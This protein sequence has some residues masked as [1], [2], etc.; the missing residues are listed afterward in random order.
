MRRW[1]AGTIG[2]S[3]ALVVT[4]CTG[5]SPA[6]TPSPTPSPTQPTTGTSAGLDADTDTTAPTPGGGGTAVVPTTVATVPATAEEPGYVIAAPD[7][8]PVDGARPTWLDDGPTRPA[9]TATVH[10]DCDTGDDDAPGTEAAPLRTLAAVGVP[11]AGTDVV[12]VGT[13]VGQ[14]LRVTW[15]G[16]AADPVV[17]DG[18]DALLRS[19]GA[20]IGRGAII[21][22]EGDHVQVWGVR[23]EGVP[24]ETQ[25]IG[26]ACPG[27]DGTYQTGYVLG[28]RLR[29]SDSV[30]ARADI[31]GTYAGVFVTDGADRALITRSV[32]HDNDILTTGRDG[33]DGDADDAGAFGVVLHG[34]WAEVSWN[35]FHDNR[36]CSPDYFVDGSAVEIFNGSANTVHHNLSVDDHVFTELGRTG[37]GPETDTPMIGNVFHANRYITRHGGHDEGTPSGERFLVT[38]G[39]GRLGPVIATVATDNRVTILGSAGDAF[40]CIDCTADTLALGGNHLAVTRHRIWYGADAGGTYA[41]VAPD[42]GTS[43]GAVDDDDVVEPAWPDLPGA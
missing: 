22:A 36:A 23:I 14:Q 3:A 19:T 43:D 11:E 35:H 29:G 26:R 12:I 21:E 7:P 27:G 28:V 31:S 34:S 20:D 17:V 42:A 37:L 33:V 5:G 8:I 6:A 15:S 2:L 38:R 30:V 13:C 24:Q 41:V 1:T 18:G 39:E 40:V 9:L 10:V 4:A 32:I 16:T 25:T